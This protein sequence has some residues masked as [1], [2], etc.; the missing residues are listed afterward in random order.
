M[1]LDLVSYLSCV[2]CICHSKLAT[3]GLH[4]LCLVDLRC[5]FPPD[6][7]FFF[8]QWNKCDS[9][10]MTAMKAERRSWRQNVLQCVCVSVRGERGG[11]KKSLF[12]HITETFVCDE[13]AQ[14]FLIME[15]LKSGTFFKILE[16]TVFVFSATTWLSVPGTMIPHLPAAACFLYRVFSPDLRNNICSTIADGRGKKKT[17][18]VKLCE[19]LNRLPAENN[20]KEWRGCVS[21][22]HFMYLY[23]CQCLFLRLNLAFVCFVW[24]ILNFETPDSQHGVLFFTP[25]DHKTEEMLRRFTWWRPCRSKYL[26]STR[27]ICLLRRGMLINH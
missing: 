5:D 2:V 19:I 12:S 22:L 4:S 14:L 27:S 16:I 13:K 23:F 26:F 1:F 11:K 7:F 3:E 8:F 24:K 18:F 10:K 20:I 9:K 15:Q 21:F 17:D 6:V 25:K